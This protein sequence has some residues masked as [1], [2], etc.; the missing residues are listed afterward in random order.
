MYHMKIYALYLPQFYETEYNNRWWGD[1][2]TEWKH[3]KN[4]K[5]LFQGHMQPK[6]PLDSRYYNLLDKNTVV[7]QTEMM[8]EYCIDGFIYYHYYFNG[9]KLL[10][11]PAENLLKWK[12]INQPFCFNWANH[13]WYRAKEGSKE[14]LMEQTYGNKEDWKQHFD[15][16]LPFFND[17]RYIKINNKPL[18]IIYDPTFNEKHEMFA[19]FD[20][21]CKNEGF[22]GL[23][24]VEECLNI[25][26]N[27]FDNFINNKS[28]ITQKIY[29][30]EPMA[31]KVAYMHHNR[32]KFQKAIF[33]IRSILNQKGY[34]KYI[35]KYDGNSLL[36]NV[37]DLNVQREDIIPGLFFEWDNTPRH[38]HRGYIINPISKDMFSKYMDYNKDK[39]FIIINAWNEWG[40]GMVLEPT[41]EN[42]Y[43]YL[44]WIKEWALNQ[45]QS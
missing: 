24:L 21:W 29:V 33:Y 34:M 31:G 40:E 9:K 35:E 23:Y 11:K 17:S 4:A 25:C 45:R 26:K 20:Q 8:H 41:E 10:E 30:T 44:E 5:P 28:K 18:F 39:D 27:S 7:W 16:L 6:H 14:L 15:Y 13:S 37:M 43:K 3:V 36:Q 22:D 32:S 12:D 38:S 1:K 2:F 19:C 42:K